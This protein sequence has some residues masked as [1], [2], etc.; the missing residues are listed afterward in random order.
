MNTIEVDDEVF[1]YLQSK[2]IPFVD[3]PNTVLR[4][5]LLSDSKPFKQRHPVSNQIAGKTTGKSS[6][7]FTKEVLNKEYSEEFMVNLPY[8]MMYKSEN[9]LIYFQNFNKNNDNLW[10]RITVKPFELLKGSPQKSYIC[11]TCPPDKIAYLIPI[12]DI[13]NQITKSNWDRD[14]LEINIDYRYS[15]WRELDWNIKHYLKEYK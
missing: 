8:R 3:S 11:L 1:Q 10:Y 2:A 6:E 15:R 4:N 12:K 7:I 14:Y 9:H 13:Q 5:I